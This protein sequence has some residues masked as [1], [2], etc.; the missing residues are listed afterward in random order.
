MGDLQLEGSRLCYLLLTLIEESTSQWTQAVGPSLTFLVR[1]WDPRS[2]AKPAQ[3]AEEIL[4]KC[5]VHSTG[6]QLP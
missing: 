2:I 5:A 1:L 3:E 6:P 4:G